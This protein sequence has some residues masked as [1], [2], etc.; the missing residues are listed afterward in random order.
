MANA[1]PSVNYNAELDRLRDVYVT[2]P[3]QSR[4]NII[5]RRIDHDEIG[6]VKLC[7]LVSGVEA[8]ARAI[9]AHSRAQIAGSIEA[10]YEKVRFAKPAAMV[11]EALRIGGKGAPEQVFPGDAWQLYGLAVEFRNLIMHECTY[12]G[13]D[14]TRSLIPGVQAVLEG[15]ADAA[16]LHR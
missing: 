12:L 6:P 13:D 3:P 1:D 14:K 15:L 7:S 5:L 16:G 8:L 11:T 9:V 10:E 2:S 4:L